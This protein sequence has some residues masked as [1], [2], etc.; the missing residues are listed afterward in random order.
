MLLVSFNICANACR[1]QVDL[2]NG[3]IEEHVRMK[4]DCCNVLVAA[5]S[6]LSTLSSLDA[7]GKKNCGLYLRENETKQVSGLFVNDILTD[8]IS[9]TLTFP[10]I[11][12]KLSTPGCS[13]CLLYSILFFRS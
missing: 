7:A 8:L 3:M 13:F 4:V 12:M 1:L 2:M 6:L 9:F 10:F 11:M 5:N